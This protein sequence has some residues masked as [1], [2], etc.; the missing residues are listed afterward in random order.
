MRII[1]VSLVALLLILTG[2]SIKTVTITVTKEVTTTV[3]I[4]KTVELR[5]SVSPSVTPTSQTITNTP[6]IVN[7]VNSVGSSKKVSLTPLFKFDFP[8]L[9]NVTYDFMIA[10]D[11]LF[12]NIIESTTGLTKTE[13]QL[14]KPLE[15]SMTYYW[16]WQPVNNKTNIR[17]EKYRGTITTY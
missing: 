14:I 2:C 12:I 5:A 15:H 13:Y 16:Q 7:V 11:P 9:E 1:F 4:T 10:S 8:D 17:G 6:N 3:E